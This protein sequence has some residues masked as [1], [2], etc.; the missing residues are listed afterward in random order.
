M[1]ESPQRNPTQAKDVAA[2]MEGH[3]VRQGCCHNLLILGLADGWW[4][5]CQLGRTPELA[6]PGL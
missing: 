6:V 5:I 4:R 2:E 3:A 1:G